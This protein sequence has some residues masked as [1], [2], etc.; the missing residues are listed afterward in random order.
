MGEIAVP[1]RL[2]VQQGETFPDLGRDIVCWDAGV[3]IGDVYA[4]VAVLDP[5]FCDVDGVG[6]EILELLEQ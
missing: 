3:V 5:L 4:K 1:D 2:L 6:R